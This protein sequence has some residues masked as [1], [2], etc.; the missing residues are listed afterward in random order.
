MNQKYE[1]NESDRL[2]ELA[3]DESNPWSGLDPCDYRGR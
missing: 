3:D 1:Q 2:D